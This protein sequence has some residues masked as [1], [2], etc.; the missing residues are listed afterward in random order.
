MPWKPL[1]SCLMPTYNRPDFIRAAV[2]SFL[3]QTWEPKE[4]IVLDDG[5]SIENLLPQD[6]RIRYSR[7]PK[8]LITGDKRNR[9]CALAAGEILC[10]FDDDDWSDPERIAFQISILEGSRKPVTG[11]G[12]LYFW[13]I[14]NLQAKI[15][16]SQI[17]GYICGTTMMFRKDWWEQHPFPSKQKAS[18][19]AII[20]P[21]AA[22][23]QVACSHQDHYMVARLHDRHTSP[24]YNIKQLV[25]KA[26]LP[27]RFWA[28]EDERTATC[29]A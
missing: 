24:K 21:A 9:A 8:K 19:N 4:L 27:E 6:D 29:H 3:A 5:P 28:N 22:A 11:F 18:D 12:T 16:R 17:T 15:Y 7:A 26:K 2:S 14:V 23:N 10:H 25:D 1:V 20:Y 13:D